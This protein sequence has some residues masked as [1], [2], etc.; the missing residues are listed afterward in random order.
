M[1]RISGLPL[2]LTLWA[3]SAVAYAEDELTALV[4]ERL[5]YMRAVAAHKWIH[6]RPVE[7]RER[8][9]RV[10]EA[11]ELAGLRHRLRRESTRAFFSAQIDA[12]KDIQR[13]WFDRWAVDGA[14]ANAPDLD[15]ELRPKLLRLGDAIVRALAEPT[16]SRELAIDTKGVTA[17]SAQALRRAAKSIRFYPSA[18]EQILEAGVLRVG[19]TG[20]Y[21]PF[22]RRAE[23]GY[24]GIDIEM[25]RDL[26]RTLDVELVFVETSWPTLTDDLREG[27]YDIAMSGVSRTFERARHGFF[28]DPYHRG[29]K[30]PL[31]R[32]S[33][34]AR[35]DSLNA[36]DSPGVR[37]IVNPG[38][39][40]ERFV[41]EHI[42]AAEIVRHPDNVTIFDELVAGRAD[43][44]ITDAIEARLVSQ[45]LA[46]LCATMPDR[47]LTYQDKG[48]LMPHDPRLQAYVNLW[49]AQRERDGSLEDLFK[50]YLE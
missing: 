39:T 23:D 42:T 18:F 16:A 9:S 7:D 44:M 30:T 11:A 2:L 21:A 26:A 28:S 50:R 31:A 10:L 15:A 29:G 34:R 4:N 49:L 5:S 48:Y 25:A 17:A 20:D 46:A 36:I 24:R 3:H 40:N 38:G 1:R 22:S 45:R 43:I 37:V 47:Q 33:D 35:F 8:E 27:R 6:H 14:P 12:A 41:N 32:C 13:F 19:T